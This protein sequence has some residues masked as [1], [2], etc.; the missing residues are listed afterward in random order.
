[1][2]SDSIILPE[3]VPYMQKDLGMSGNNSM[4]GTPRLW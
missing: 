2:R 3:E 4:S 1:M